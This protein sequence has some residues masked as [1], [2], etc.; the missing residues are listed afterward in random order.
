MTNVQMQHVINVLS[1]IGFFILFSLSA[2]DLMCGAE[3]FFLQ[4]FFNIGQKKQKNPNI[5]ACGQ[6]PCT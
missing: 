6:S 4:P 2:F 1:H 5:D 3:G